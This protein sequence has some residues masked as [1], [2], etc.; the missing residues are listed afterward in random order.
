MTTLVENG[1]S[2]T[3]EELYDQVWSEPMWTLAARFGLSDVGLAKTCR[4]YQIPVP[5]RVYWQQKHAGQPVKR[6]KLP[7]LSISSSERLGAIAF[8]SRGR[9]RDAA[10]GGERTEAPVILVPEVLTDPHPLV[11]H[12]ILALRRAKPAKN[13]TLPRSSS[14]DYLDVR[15]SLGTVDRAMRVMDA[16]LR[17]CEDRG[18]AVSIQIQEKEAVSQVEVDGEAVAFH[19]EE[20]IDTVAISPEERKPVRGLSWQGAPERK[21]VPNGLLGFHIDADWYW[22]Q[23]NARRSWRDGEEQRLEECLGQVL[24]GLEAAAVAIKGSRAESEARDRR[25]KEEARQRKRD[26]WLA[27]GEKKRR[28]VIHEELGSLRLINELRAY[29]ALRRRHVADPSQVL[30]EW[31]SWVSAYADELEGQI[32]KYAGPKLEPF[33]ENSYYY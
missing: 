6:T 15:V 25:F 26:A 11:A 7:R 1:I 3:H 27:S 24:V 20:G 32:L 19:V 12:T 5:P 18:Y 31:L 28:E 30:E 21:D 13:G 8:R 17:A 14:G 9:Q 2:V 29:V 4:R 22:Y 33:N 10:G 16:L 23:G